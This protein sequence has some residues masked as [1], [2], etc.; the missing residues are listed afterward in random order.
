MTLKIRVSMN[1]INESEILLWEQALQ[2]TPGKWKE[3]IPLLSCNQISTI[4]PAA[5]PTYDPLSWKLK[6]CTAI[7]SLKDTEKLEAAGKALQLCQ[8]CELINA[9]AEG[10]SQLFLAL[11]PLFVGLPPSVFRNLL[12]QVNPRHL[13]VLKQEGLTEALQHHLSVLSQELKTQLMGNLDLTEK[14][15]KEFATLDLENI[16]ADA[17]H[18]AFQEIQTLSE[19]CRHLYDET[20]NALALAW[21]TNRLDL[22]EQLSGVKETSQKNLSHFIG[23]P[24]TSTASATG[25]WK[26]L[27]KRLNEVFNSLGNVYEIDNLP[28]IEA[29][30][31]FSV[32]YAKDYWDVG[33]L[34]QI[35]NKEH[36]E[37]NPQAF[38]EQEIS[39]HRAQLFL[40][41][42]KNL[43]S[44]GL[45]TLK[46]LKE[47]GI[48][49]KK[50]LT[51]YVRAHLPQL[52]SR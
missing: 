5:T 10:E 23:S 30:I 47:S 28:A 45:H 3:N 21:N 39:D 7:K 44:L 41:A 49:S 27:G 12:Y 6:I 50:A 9:A 40:S 13:K 11:P 43:E 25:L 16:D 34:P 31:A 1:A 20:K 46:D 42:E 37:L 2:W 35:A 15:E 22:I 4:L 51:D 26:I 8:I 32:W 33:L 36:L 18:A 48:Y 17:I 19:E 52:L 14:K 38:S 24:L 29:L